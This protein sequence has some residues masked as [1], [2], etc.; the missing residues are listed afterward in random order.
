VIAIWLAQIKPGHGGAG[1]V[2]VSV[3]EDGGLVNA[4]DLFVCDS[5]L[6]ASGNLCG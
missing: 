2:V 6:V 5:A 1:A 3:D 4:L